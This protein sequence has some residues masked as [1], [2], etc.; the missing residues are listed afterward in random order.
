MRLNPV[1]TELTT[2]ATD[3]AL[4][5]L[6]VACIVI[7]YRHRQG[8]PWKAGL[9]S[10]ILALLGLASVL[11]ALAHGLDLPA[12]LRDALWQPLY[13]ALGLVVALFVVAAAFDRFGLELGSRL[14]PIMAL[15]GIGF[16]A[17][18]RLFTGTFLVFILYEAVGMLVALALYVSL[19]RRRRGEGWV[20][21][22]VAGI[23]LTIVAAAIQATE[24]VRVT[25]IWPF[26]HNGVF[27]LIQ[28]AALIVLVAGVTRSLKMH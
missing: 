26:D 4:A 15:V 25:L 13:L 12:P 11:G 17:I 16:Y 9:W 19:G 14:L 2:A 22:M 8:D 5:L 3:A 24:G 23:A 1:P 7:L 18:T 20:R 6:A 28:M 21:L 27:H 10:L